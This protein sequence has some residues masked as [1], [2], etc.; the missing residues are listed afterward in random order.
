MHVHVH[1]PHPV[2]SALLV[3]RRRGPEGEIESDSQKP[4]RRQPRK[5]GQ[6][7]ASA[8]R[9]NLRG[10]ANLWKVGPGMGRSYTAI[11]RAPAKTEIRINHQSC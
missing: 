10:L 3:I 6:N 7:A 9:K 2:S 4:Q 8:R 11:H 5:P 1:D